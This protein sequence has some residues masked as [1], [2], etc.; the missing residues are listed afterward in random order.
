VSWFKKGRKSIFNC[1]LSPFFSLR[2]LRNY[3]RVGKRVE[4]ICE[5]K[6]RMSRYKLLKVIP[7]ANNI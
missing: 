5:F 4:E 3:G 1:F 6:R 7:N 2:E